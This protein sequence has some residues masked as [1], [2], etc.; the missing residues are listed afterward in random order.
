MAIKKKNFD[1][2]HL[3]QDLVFQV[4]KFFMLTLKQF[5]SFCDFLSSVRGREEKRILTKES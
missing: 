2:W 1:S 5:P 3:Q 4:R